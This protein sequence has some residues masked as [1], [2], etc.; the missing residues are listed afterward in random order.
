MYPPIIS[1]AVQYEDCIVYWSMLS[2]GTLCCVAQWK[3]TWNML[4]C[5]HILKMRAVG[6]CDMSVQSY[7]ATYFQ[8]PEYSILYGDCTET[9]KS[10]IFFAPCNIDSWTYNF[11]LLLY[12]TRQFQAYNF[13]WHQVQCIAKCN[14]I[15]YGTQKCFEGISASIH[16]QPHIPPN[17]MS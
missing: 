9:F 16:R 3:F 10:H 8:F 12:T 4:P 14:A 6:S 7:E 15:S 5:G 13:A 1:Y 2:I 11:L 17:L